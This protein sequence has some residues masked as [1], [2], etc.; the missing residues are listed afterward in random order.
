MR[1]FI[2]K[3]SGY[4]ILLNFIFCYN[5]AHAASFTVG[6]VR[7]KKGVTSMKEIK[8]RNIVPQSL[9][10]S[11]G[12]AGLSTLMHFYLNDPVSEK[13]II[14]N[15]LRSVDLKKIKERKGFS[16]LD[17][18]KF[19]ESKGY[20]VTG[21]KMDSEFLHELQTPVLVP[22]KFKAY[23]HFVIVKAAIGDRVFIADPAVGNMT[24]KISRFETI[25][26]GGIGLVIER[27]GQQ[28]DKAYALRVSQEETIFADYKNALKTVQGSVIRTAIF[29]SEYK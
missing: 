11:C 10:F 24:M 3:F 17:L 4:C 23:Q 8:S 9:D 19:A 15:I 25:W 5:V 21:Y 16:L 27:P 20:K 26:L 14:N 12:A 1:E 7:V 29:P 28:E 6:G 2:L 13:E 22:I 18:K